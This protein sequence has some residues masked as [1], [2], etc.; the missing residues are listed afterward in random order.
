MGC[1]H[2]ENLSGDGR[3]LTRIKIQIIIERKNKMTIGMLPKYL[4][5]FCKHSMCKII[6]KKRICLFCGKVVRGNGGTPGLIIGIDS[7]SRVL[8]H[9]ETMVLS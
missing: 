1:S 7:R 3:P 8:L 4:K 2:K 6:N 9:V 5:P